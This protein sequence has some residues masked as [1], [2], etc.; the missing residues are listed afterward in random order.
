VSRIGEVTMTTATRDETIRANVDKADDVNRWL[1]QL[2]YPTRRHDRGAIGADLSDLY[3]S[4]ATYRALIDAL[5]A[6]P[7]EQSD[8]A[9]DRVADITS[10]LRHMAWHIRSVTRRRERLEARLD[11]DAE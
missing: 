4:A 10:E 5:L 7:P 3:V 1:A 8:E 2:G 6:L 11:P 9:A